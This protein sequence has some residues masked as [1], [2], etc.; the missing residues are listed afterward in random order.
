MCFSPRTLLQ[1][2]PIRSAFTY[3]LNNSQ[4]CTSSPPDALIFVISKSKNFESRNAI[5][6]TWGN[7]ARLTSINQYSHLRLALLFLL[8]IDETQL[9]NAQLEQN[10]FHD[11]VQVHLPQY[12]SLS[13]YR[14]MAILHWTETFCPQAKLTIKTD[15]DVFLN[16]YL[17]TN[18]IDTIL[19]NITDDQPIRH[20]QYSHPAGQIYGIRIS[21]AHVVRSSS[22]PIAEGNRYIATYDEYP[23]KFYPDYM[24]GFGYL[25]TRQAR[26]LL[27]CSFFRDSKP[28]F[29]SDVYVTGILPEY[30]NISRR[31]LGLVISYLST[32]DCETFFSQTSADHFACASSS[33]YG[34]S[35]AS[36]FQRF[37]VYWKLI[38]AHRNLYLRYKISTLFE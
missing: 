11:L 26:A 33:H 5:R 27:L 37:N 8:D 19:K 36:I 3:Q 35:Q 10:V 17:L 7:V 29:M 28:F 31:S 15:D 6:R 34:T 1:R 21:K 13:S 30:L 4:F 12:Y 38:D 32:D 14:D 2:E 25:V 22:D 23:C 18:A 16:T 9:L 24:S 20:C